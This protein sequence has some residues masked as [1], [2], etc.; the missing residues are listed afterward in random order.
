LDPV[1]L[2]ASPPVAAPPDKNKQNTD[3]VKIH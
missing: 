2:P 3:D 1:S